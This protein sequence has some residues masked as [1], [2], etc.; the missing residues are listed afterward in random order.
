M[1]P[2]KTQFRVEIPPSRSRE[3]A[4]RAPMGE[5]DLRGKM[6][7]V[8]PFPDHPA[9]EIVT[10][11]ITLSKSILSILGPV[12]PKCRP[13][14]PKPRPDGCAA[15]P[16]HPPGARGGNRVPGRS[17]EIAHRAATLFKFDD[18]AA[19]GHADFPTRPPNT[20]PNTPPTGVISDITPS[21][22]LSRIR[23]IQ[24]TGRFLQSTHPEILRGAFS[25]SLPHPT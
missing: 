12:Y 10:L 16:F 6:G 17:W 21:P 11:S 15:R 20:P 18:L 24:E 1:R 19:G 7:R 25:P 13:D 8:T 4:Y 3:A 2:G 5:I 14:D 23:F 22:D 9:G